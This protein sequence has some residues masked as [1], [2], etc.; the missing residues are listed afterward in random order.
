[1]TRQEWWRYVRE[2]RIGL[3]C[4]A[5]AIGGVAWAFATGHLP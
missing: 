3:A 5:V 1:M 4:L 2:D